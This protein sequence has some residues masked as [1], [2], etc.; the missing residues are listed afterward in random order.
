MY[1]SY[2]KPER[3]LCTKPCYLPI[4]DLLRASPLAKDANELFTR[5]TAMEATSVFVLLIINPTQHSIFLN[6]FVGHFPSDA[7]IM[8]DNTFNMDNLPS[9]ALTH[10]ASYLAVPSRALFAVALS[11]TNEESLAIVGR[12]QCDILDFGGIHKDLAAKLTDD[13]IRDI[14]LRVDAVNRVKRLIL[15]G[16]VNITGAGLEPLRGSLVIEQIDLDIK[17]D[18]RRTEHRISCN[19]VLPILDSIIEQERCALKHLHFPEAWRGRAWGQITLAGQICDYDFDHFLLRYNQMWAQRQEVLSC[20]KCSANLPQRRRQSGTWA[21]LLWV[22]DVGGPWM[23]TIADSRGEYGIQLHTCHGCLK[24]YCL[25]CRSDGSSQLL[26]HCTEC[27]RVYCA[28][29]SLVLECVDPRE[30]G[31]GQRFCSGCAF[32]ERRCRDCGRVCCNDCLVRSCE[33]C[34]C[35]CPYCDSPVEYCTSCY[36][37]MCSDCRSQSRS[38]GITICDDCV[39]R[40]CNACRLDMA[41]SNQ[42]EEC[43]SN[44]TAPLLMEHIKELTTKNEELTCKNKELTLDNEQLRSKIKSLRK[45]EGNPDQEG[46]ADH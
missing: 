10:I 44:L 36:E 34:G 3:H 33:L 9:S 21:D 4:F 42:A 23:C 24:H 29:C 6:Y 41:L 7:I 14:L 37:S 25:N 28:D 13:H 26:D 16:C 22:Q 19:H 17:D 12:T 46:H 20:M 43:C 39:E 31:C 38:K 27:D 45:F 18:R 1:L 8:Q 5:T 30:Y 40:T 11:V 32:D 35:L 15:T 2:I